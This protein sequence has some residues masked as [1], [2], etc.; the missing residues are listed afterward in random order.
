MADL[1]TITP[2]LMGLL[3]TAVA[4][5]FKTTIQLDKNYVALKTAFNCFLE[6]IGKGA[7][8][9]LDS[10]NP[11]PTNIRVLLRKYVAGQ[12][13]QPERHELKEWLRGAKDDQQI[14]KAE[15]SAVIQLLA[16]M[17]TAKLLGPNH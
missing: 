3:A 11:T 4:W 5:L 2:W 16:A 7:A 12:L 1:N 13:S 15:R 8:K 6:G 9:V 17:E 10:P 14:S